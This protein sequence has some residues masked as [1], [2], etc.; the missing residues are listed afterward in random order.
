MAGRVEKVL[1]YA[2]GEGHDHLVL[3]AWG[4]GVFRNDPAMI[5][6]IVSGVADGSHT[7]P[8]PS[9]SAGVYYEA[10]ALLTDEPLKLSNVPM[11]A[12][13]NS[14]ERLLESL[15]AAI[16]VDDAKVAIGLSDVVPSSNRF[17]VELNGLSVALF[18]KQQSFFERGQQPRDLHLPHFGAKQT[19]LSLQ[20]SLDLLDQRVLGL[21]VRQ[22]GDALQSV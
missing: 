13:I 1:A 21:V 9:H 16:E 18:M 12:D 11:L 20:L 5:E 14:L 19:E 6:A 7:W 2:A 15:G 22:A 3:G 10:A 8:V 17:P 4:C